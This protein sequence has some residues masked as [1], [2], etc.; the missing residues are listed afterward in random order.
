MKSLKRP[1]A[2]FLAVLTLF[3]TT[4]SCQREKDE[5]TTASQNINEQSLTFEVFFSQ[6]P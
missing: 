3:G 5:V 2:V 4:V 6:N 1:V